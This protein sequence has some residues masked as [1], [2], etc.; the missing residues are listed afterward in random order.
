VHV[1][2]YTSRRPHAS[3][4]TQHD[5]IIPPSAPRVSASILGTRVLQDKH[6]VIHRT[7]YFFMLF[8]VSFY[9]YIFGFLFLFSRPSG[10]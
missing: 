2:E 4:S 6:V 5:L 3:P 8:M 7:I 1:A 9:L 10:V